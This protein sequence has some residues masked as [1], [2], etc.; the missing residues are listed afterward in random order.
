[1]ITIFCILIFLIG[2][3]FVG[4]PVLLK[5]RVKNR[6]LHRQKVNYE[7]K[8][9]TVLLIA[10]NEEGTIA[11][12]IQNIFSLDY[13]QEQIKIIVVDD[14]SEDNTV[15]IVESFD[16]SRI[17]IIS[18]ACRSGKAH[19]LNKG[20]ALA[21][22]E[23]VMMVDAR[24]EISLNSLR[25]LA[26]W[27][28]VGSK[29]AAVSGEL[30][31]RTHKSG[32]ESGMDAYQKYEKFIRKSESLV[33]GVPGVSGA[34]Y[35]LRRDLFSPIPDDTILDDVLIPMLAAKKGH[36]IGYD[37][38]AIAWDIPSHDLSREKKRKTRTLNGNYQLLFRNLQWCT[39]G[40]HPLWFEYLSH[41][42]SRL[43]APFFAISVFLISLYL[44]CHGS[45][46]AGVFNIMFLIVIA[47]YPMSLAIPAI[48]KNKLLRIASSF[49]ALNWFNLL[50]FFQYLFTDKKQSWK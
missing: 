4:Y 17:K 12:K 18:N 45:Y 48:N 21:D 19:G 43:T 11:E 50:G 22:T 2:Y 49:V 7:N 16:D 28:H 47:L 37:D 20:M 5:I 24:Q 40:G 25:D 46:L 32:V 39:P 15:S 34:L 42:V 8:D 31:L 38:R 9:I 3:T 35:M 10:C 44:S 13:S 23:L 33:S 6:A 26:S 41:K 36:W 30:K 14:A 1:M 29:V 27:F